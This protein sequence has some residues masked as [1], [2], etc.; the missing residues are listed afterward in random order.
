MYAIRSYYDIRGA[1]A[2]LFAG[3]LAVVIGGLLILLAAPTAGE[4]G[5]L[6][7]VTGML[8]IGLGVL[9]VYLTRRM[10]RRYAALSVQ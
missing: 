5:V 1:R 4:G 7:I 3:R 8:S 10:Q 6:N 9:V 2:Y